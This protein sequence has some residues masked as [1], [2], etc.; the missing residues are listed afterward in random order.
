[1]RRR[2]AKEGQRQWILEQSGCV[3]EWN[4]KSVRNHAVVGHHIRCSKLAK[5]I[6]KKWCY[7]LPQP[8][9]GRQHPK[10]VPILTPRVPLY[11]GYRIIRGPRKQE[12]IDGYWPN[13]MLVNFTLFG[14][15]DALHFRLPFFQ[16]ARMCGFWEHQYDDLMMSHYC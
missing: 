9:G 5:Q 11:L 16:F 3:P 8:A 4:R 15:G 10:R 2:N 1:M 13:Y 6:P 12:V 14:F 7:H